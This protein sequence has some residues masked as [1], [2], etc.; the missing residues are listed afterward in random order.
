M[1]TLSLVLRPER[2][3]RVAQALRAAGVAHS[4][5][6]GAIRLSPHCYNTADEIDEKIETYF[7]AGVELVWVVF[8]L[9]RRIRVYD[10]P[11][12]AR[13]LSED[14]D[15]EGGNVLPGFRIPIRDLFSSLIKPS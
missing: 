5:R 7:G 1:T 15:L 12:Q 4:L 14:D 2:P 9:R 11:T 3:E 6:E 8:P 10:S 13:V